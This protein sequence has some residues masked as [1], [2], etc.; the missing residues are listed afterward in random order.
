MSYIVDACG[1]LRKAEL[2][3]GR[4]IPITR[5]LY[6]EN[7]EVCESSYRSSEKLRALYR[8]SSLA[9]KNFLLPPDHKVKEEDLVNST[10]YREVERTNPIGE[11]HTA[12]ILIAD[13]GIYFITED[14]IKMLWAFPP[15]RWDVPSP[16]TDFLKS[17][18]SNF[19]ARI[20]AYGFK[21]F[22]AFSPSTLCVF[23]DRWAL[24]TNI[25]EDPSPD[26]ARTFAYCIEEENRVV[27]Y[28]NLWCNFSNIEN[29]RFLESEGCVKLC[30][31]TDKGQRVVKISFKDPQTIDILFAEMEERVRHCTH[32]F[33]DKGPRVWCIEAS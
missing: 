19:T 22:C 7:K 18:R 17:T 9:V 33:G 24:L 31:E 2:P 15:P 21:A 5:F 6:I 25:K 32:H 28:G 8:E 11:R 16:I 23:C 27:Y 20:T 1:F 10:K 13:G 3:E 30:I 12:S 4:E 26:L 14:R 29:A